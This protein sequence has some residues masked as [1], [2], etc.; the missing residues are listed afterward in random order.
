VT[1]VGIA[2]G[3]VAAIATTRLIASLLFGVSARDPFTFVA[4]AVV[5][6]AVSLAA[7]WLPARRA[8][9]ISP[10]EALREE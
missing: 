4:T 6:G 9:A 8:A 3:L 5:L 1:L 2:L 7:T 10:L